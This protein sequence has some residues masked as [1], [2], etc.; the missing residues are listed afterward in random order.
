MKRT[1]N[2]IILELKKS[3]FSRY[4]IIGV[5][6]LLLF[7]I[8]SAIYC[9]ENAADY[10]PGYMDTYLIKDGQY[11]ENPDFPLFSLYENWV[12]ADRMSL[13]ATIFYYLLPICAA[14]P[15]SWTFNYE[16]K[17]GYLRN[18]YIRTTKSEY[19]FAKV[20]CAFSMGL[21]TV[22]IP[23]V[24]N[25]ILVS[26]FI[27]Y[28]QPNPSYIFYNMIYF[29]NMGSD[30]YFSHPFIHMILFALLSSLYGGIYSVFSFAAS[31]YVKNIIFI[32][33]S[34]FF[35]TFLIQYVEGYYINSLNAES[36]VHNEYVPIIFIRAKQLA[37]QVYTGNVMLITFIIITFSLI[38]IFWLGNKNETL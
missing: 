19:L 10:N 23:I 13:A 36:L 7:S 29:G 38:S 25:I 18:I 34:P 31:L 3:I 8:L 9:I 16:Y 35:I 32:L 5:S 1:K 20:I 15:C 26:A 28:Y 12:G 21:L 2:L 6:I 17:T 24:V 37:N 30:L 11:T 33:F 4:F 14:I 22:L 27:P